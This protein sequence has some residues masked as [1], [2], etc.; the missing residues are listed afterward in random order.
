MQTLRKGSR[1]PQTELLQLA[2]SRGSYL[3]VSGIDGI[4]GSATQAAVT[5]FQRRAGLSADG[6]AGPRT[7]AALTPLLTGFLRHTIRRGDT[8]FRIAAAYGS[9][10]S[11]IDTANPGIDPLNLPVGALITVPLG[12]DVVPTNISFTSTV[13]EYVLRGLRARYPFLSVGRMGRSVLGKPLYRLSIGEGRNEVFYNASHHAN[14]WIT[15]PL[16]LK[17]LENYAL[18]RATGGSIGGRSAH[19]LCSAATLY[20]A[21]LVNPDG[22]DLVTGELS[23]GVAYEQARRIG[24]DYPGLPFPSGWKANING[25]DLNLQYP[26]GWEEAKAIKFSQGFTAPAPRD[27]VGAGPL[28]QPESRAVY[29]FTLEH[30][31]TLTL[32]Y[33]TQGQVI[34]W[35]YLD[36]EPPGSLAI[37]QRFSRLSGYPLEQTP[38]AS[39]YAGYKD[40][41]IDR[42]DRPGYTVEAGIGRSPLPLSQF[43]EIYRDNEGILTEGMIPQ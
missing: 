42:Y 10:L 27:Y 12:F 21:P 33:H 43:D 32:S 29:N 41:F 23:S 38:A 3:P 15:T 18:A 35:K 5:K 22:V 2:L 30:D 1:G 28:D 14:E 34:F 39:A 7:W 17:F 8:L 24:N 31:F 4:F 19:M 37:G 26:A 13:T 25:V 6:I 16:L 9:S 11:A 36:R 40:W 20:I